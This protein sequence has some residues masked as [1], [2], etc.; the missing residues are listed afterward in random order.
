MDYLIKSLQEF[1]YYEDP[2]TIEWISEPIKLSDQIKN[3]IE[4]MRFSSGLG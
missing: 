4:F 3:A 1:E 2:D